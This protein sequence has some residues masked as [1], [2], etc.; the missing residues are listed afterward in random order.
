MVKTQILGVS[1]SNLIESFVRD[2]WGMEECGQDNGT[3]RWVRT[4]CTKK[5]WELEEVL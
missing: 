4:V 5:R 2:E 3:G 1:A